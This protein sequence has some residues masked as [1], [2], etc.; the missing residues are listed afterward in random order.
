MGVKEYKRENQA[1]IEIWAD[2]RRPAMKISV[3]TVCYNSAETLEQ[4]ICSVIMQKYTELEYIIIDGGSTDGTKDIIR[5]YNADISFWISEPDKGIYDAMNKGLGFCTGDVVA[6]L[7]SDDWYDKNV[8]KRVNYYF[9]EN[10]VDIVSGKTYTAYGQVIKE[11]VFDRTDDENVFFSVIYP[12]PALFIKRKLFKKMGGY[13]MNYKIAADTDWIIRAYCAGAKILKVDDY[14]TY[15][16][17]GGLSSRNVYESQMEQYKSAMSCAQMHEKW[18]LAER[19]KK[20][21]TQVLED[22]RQDIRINDAISNHLA[23]ARKQID[24]QKKCLIWGA[25]QRGK[26]CL[27]IMMRLELPVVGFVDILHKTAVE[28]YPVFS[29]DEI[30]TE[31]IVCITPKGHEEEIQKQLLQKGMQACNIIL[32]TDL[33]NKLAEIGEM[34]ERPEVI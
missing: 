19:I 8:L 26:K 1:G 27:E 28:E 23:I 11:N 14:F 33:L 22:I 13:D 34:Q 17:D 5:K 9:E 31:C 25:G 21:Y 24:L 32:Y 20:H 3:V 6:F 10:D 16:R 7:N 15:F 4:T 12:H 30:D 2:Y 18:E 29:P